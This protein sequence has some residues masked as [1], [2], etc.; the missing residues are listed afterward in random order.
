MLVRREPRRTE[1]LLR[2]LAV[3]TG[4]DAKTTSRDGGIDDK[5]AGVGLHLGE[6]F[7]EPVGGHMVEVGHHVGRIA[8]YAG[9]VLAAFELCLAHYGRTL[10]LDPLHLGLEA[11]DG[12]LVA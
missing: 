11:V 12:V 9:L 8:T 6:G 5:R 7:V 3:H 1:V 2:H 4:N 10:H